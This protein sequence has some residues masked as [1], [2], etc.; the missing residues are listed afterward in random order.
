MNGL[1]TTST[2]ALGGGLAA[3]V[4]LLLSLVAL[5]CFWGRTFTRPKHPPVHFETV[6]GTAP[7]YSSDMIPKRLDG[8]I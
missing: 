3:G 2:A 1:S 5:C 4:A 7:A 8:S 6:V